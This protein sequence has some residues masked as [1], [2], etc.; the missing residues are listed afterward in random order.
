MNPM[1]PTNLVTIRIHMKS[2]D[3]S[4]NESNFH[5]SLIT[6]QWKFILLRFL[7]DQT[8][9]WSKWTSY[10]EV[11]SSGVLAG[12]QN[13]NKVFVG[14]TFDEDGIFVPAKIIPAIK[15]SF[16][17][18]D[19]AEESSDQVEFLDHAADYHWV[20]SEDA[21]IADAVT[22]SG[23]YIG[24]GTY[25]G[26]IVVGRVDTKTK[27]LV[28]SFDGE[29]LSLASFDVLIYKSKGVAN[30]HLLSELLYKMS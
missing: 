15:S 20:K 13:G 16:Y 28:G 3:L 10:D 7:T 14:R 8:F 18:Y 2:T 24:R 26:N 19:D 30:Y 12:E 23:S 4:S 29:V 22:V 1:N 25:N 17:A 21:N 11:E 9:S 27:Q 5:Y 6:V